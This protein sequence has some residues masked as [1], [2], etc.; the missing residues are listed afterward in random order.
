VLR[1]ERSV[2]VNIMIM[3]AFVKL[4]EIVATHKELVE[5]VNALER[6][7]QQHD[8]QIKAVF[9]AIRNFIEEPRAL[10]KHRIGFLAEADRKS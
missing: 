10:P 5:K 9:E 7:Y 1:S 3:R 6:K 8:V 4:R 2:R